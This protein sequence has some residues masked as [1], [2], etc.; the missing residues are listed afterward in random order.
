MRA[1]ILKN[2]QMCKCI[3]EEPWIIQMHEFNVSQMYTLG[4]AKG[5]PV[6]RSPFCHVEVVI[7]LPF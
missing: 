7:N 2:R 4:K 5:S 3:D 6:P 1:K